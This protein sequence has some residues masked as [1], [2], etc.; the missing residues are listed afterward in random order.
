M[1]PKGAIILQVAAMN[2]QSDALEMAG[3]LQ[4]KHYP[5]FVVPPG[6][7]HYYHVQVGPYAD[8]KSAE[9]VRKALE[10]EGFKTIVKR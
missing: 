7:D 2:K 9:A 10:N 4:K 1:I 5:A 3:A 6:A 8:L